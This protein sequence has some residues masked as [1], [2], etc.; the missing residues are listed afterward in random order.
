MYQ[1]FKDVL[2]GNWLSTQM[3]TRLRMQLSMSLSTW[4]LKPQIR[5][6]L[7]G[8]CMQFFGFSCLIR[9]GTTTWL[10]KVFQSLILT[11]TL[12]YHNIIE[13]IVAYQILS[14]IFPTLNDKNFIHF[15][16]L[17][18]LITINSQRLNTCNFKVFSICQLYFCHIVLP[19]DTTKK[20]RRFRGMKLEWGLDKA[21]SLKAFNEVSN[22]FLVDD[23]CVFGAEVFVCKER[24]TGKGECVSL[25]KDAIA[26]KHVWKIENYSKLNAES[27]DSKPFNAGDKKWY[28]WLASLFFFLMCV[29][30]K[31]SLSHAFNMFFFSL[32]AC[33]SLLSHIHTL[34]AYLTMWGMMHLSDVYIIYMRYFLVSGEMREEL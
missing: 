28:L 23:T 8:K 18:S 34:W 15:V 3:E 4:Q 14:F 11:Y 27:Y 19:I 12:V 32:I 2:T 21:I 1:S 16:N 20:E 33:K 5:S 7:V 24:S 31:K 30:G 17:F 29:H 6:L 9:P 25:I 10:F 26:N 13:I 22:G